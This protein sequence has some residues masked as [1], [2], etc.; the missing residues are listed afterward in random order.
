MR[1]KPGPLIIVE[2]DSDD[3]EIFKEIFENLKV[4]NTILFF[5]DGTEALS[6]LQTTTEQPFLIICDINLP[7]MNGLEFRI[8]IN[9]DVRLRKKSIPF[10]FFSTNATGDTVQR[11]YDLTVQG[12]FTK[13]STLEELQDTLGMIIKYWTN[14]KHPNN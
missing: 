12:Y 6:Y 13:S 3:Q 7:K 8:E 1:S 11:A 10:V 9:N 4:S 5:S 14:C 2:D